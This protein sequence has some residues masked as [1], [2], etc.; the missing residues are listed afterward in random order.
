MGHSLVTDN[1]VTAIL[2]VLCLY[3]RPADYTLLSGL[4][5]ATSI[6]GDRIMR[7]KVIVVLTFLFF[8]VSSSQAGNQ[9]VLYT[10]T[11]G[12]DGSQPYQAG[13]I[14]DPAGNLYGVTQYGGAYGQGTVFQ[15]TPSP[16]GVWTETVLHSFTGVPDGEQPQ[17]GLAIDA[18]GNLYGTTSWGG[19][20][21]AW[22]GTVFELSP[23]SS[24]WTFTV[25]HA[26]TNGQD[27]CS[28]QGGD[29]HF[30]SGSIFGT[31]AGGGA[32]SQGTVFSLPAS[33]GTE[34][35]WPLRGGNGKFP[36]GLGSYLPGGANYGTA[37]F[38][39][40]QQVGT[41]FE[42]NGPTGYSK[43]SPIVSVDCCSLGF[44]VADLPL[45]Q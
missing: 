27:G 4:L 8:S 10:F 24:G 34:W 12:V 11:G 5:S 25:L 18:A 45:A 15:L 32:G 26:F 22:C 39:G 42:L 36:G 20:P 38:G 1:C 21:S 2:L 28:P 37:N 19:D 33:G 31:T 44:L 35:V 40:T 3:S 6:Q 43:S 17:G 29:L 41:I 7:A 9:K 23:S 16:D 13:V 30:D 14:F